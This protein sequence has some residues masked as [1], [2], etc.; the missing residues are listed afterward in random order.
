MAIL[1]VSVDLVFAVQVGVLLA[2][3]YFFFRM[4]NSLEIEL[5]H[6]ES[7]NDHLLDG[8]IL[9]YRLQGPLF[10]G[11]IERLEQAIL[12]QP[13][14]I[15]TIILIFAWVPMIDMGALKLLEKYIL[16]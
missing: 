9:E 4:S 3:L 12:K 6:I 2:I 14:S 11:A 10:F 13:Q 15:Q 8:E 7:L 16:Q 5:K 1:S